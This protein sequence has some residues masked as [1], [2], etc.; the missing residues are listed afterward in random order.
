[1]MSNRVI[2]IVM[3]MRGEMMG[4]DYLYIDVSLPICANSD[5]WSNMSM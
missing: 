5:A 1:M 2:M 4:G 3:K